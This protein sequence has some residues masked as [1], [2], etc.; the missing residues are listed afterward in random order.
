MKKKIL[1]AVDSSIHS[2]NAMD[3][4][5]KMGSMMKE[6]SFVLLNIQPIIS[7]Y[8][9]EEAL[10]R[11]KSKEELNRLYK[12]HH[13]NSQQF[14]ETCKEKLIRKGVPGDCIEVRTQPRV[15][16]VAEDIIKSAEIGSYDAVLVGRS[17]ASGIR[18]LL[19]GS[20]TSNLLSQAHF[21]P[22]WIVDGTVTSEK[23]LVAVDGTPSSLKAVDHVSF[24]FSE[25]RD[26]TIEFLNII[27]LIRDVCE[28]DTDTL[29]TAE[30]EEAMLISN[31]KCITDFSAVARGVLKNAGFSD[32]QIVFRSEKHMYSPGKAII[33][34]VKKENFGTVIVGKS[35]AKET[36]HVGRVAGHII[37]KISDRAVWIV[38]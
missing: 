24:I 32:D 34:I 35:D 31:E 2:N 15:Y 37:Q 28:V 26:L 22:L 20:V 17:G 23:V 18:E 1:I 4:A 3:Y 29:E 12:S 6:A 9:V 36:S 21:I 27:P 30:L 14:L 7:Q 11:P 5:L 10:K 13:M 8:L 33:D 16:S 38:P 25:N 19:M